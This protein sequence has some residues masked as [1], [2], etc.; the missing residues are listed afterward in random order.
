[1]LVSSYGA[2]MPGDEDLYQQQWNLRPR[3][4]A[5]RAEAKSLRQRNN[6]EFKT[7]ES[8]L[9][10]E[11]DR[12]AREQ[13]GVEQSA[14]SADIQVNVER[15]EVASL[16]KQIQERE[17]TAAAAEKRGAV[18]DAS[19]HR[20][21]ADGLRATMA[22]HEARARQAELDAAELRERAAGIDRHRTELKVERDDLANH[23]FA[24]EREIDKL[25]QQADL[26]Q[27]ARL[28]FTEA[29]VAGDDVG[30]RS[31]LSLEAEA[32]VT[33]AGAIEVDRSVLRVVIPEVPDTTPG[34]DDP[35]GPLPDGAV[36]WSEYIE[37]GAATTDVLGGDAVGSI[38][39]DAPA[40]DDQ[41]DSDA[42]VQTDDSSDAVAAAFDE[43]PAQ[44]PLDHVSEQPLTFEQP[45]GFAEETNF[46]DTA[47]F[48]PASTPDESFAIDAV[49]TSE[50]D[51]SFDV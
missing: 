28:K 8:D 14:K 48:E 45:A 46:A 13:Y 41:A 23:T 42:V 36:D 32:L 21:F 38:G 37:T 17:A 33:K 49:T 9:G 18:Q 20:E 24:A 51:T 10:I 39:Q 12:L 35:P 47:S 25:E 16:V 19:E 3:I 5:L 1:M 22:T 31:T 29:D 50:S 44:D 4:D 40:G 27:Q 34:I 11:R 30:R 15:R 43:Q 6:A 2:S 26:L 7:K